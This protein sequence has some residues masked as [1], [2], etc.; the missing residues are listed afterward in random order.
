M[1]NYIIYSLIFICNISFAQSNFVPKKINGKWGVVKILKDNREIEYIRPIYDTVL[2]LRPSYYEKENTN[3]FCC[4]LNNELNIIGKNSTLL[5]KEI[6][7]N[8]VHLNKIEGN[9]TLLC[10]ENKLIA[11]INKK[12][13]LTIK[14][15]SFIV[16]RGDEYSTATYIIKSG[17]K[18]GMISG[19]L[20][21]HDKIYLAPKYDSIMSVENQSYLFKLRNKYG[22]YSLADENNPTLLLPCTYDKIVLLSEVANENYVPPPP[23]MGK[24]KPIVWEATT[25]KKKI[26]V[27]DFDTR[28]FRTYMVLPPP[29]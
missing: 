26:K 15:D 25:N 16:S 4:R 19:Y 23:E 14:I 22:L 20:F 6:N 24:N 18:Y 9:Y 11:I 3:I 29:E 21:E 28:N 8:S 13:H 12:S 1:K 7:C 5:Y 17:N 27:K 10:N 2:E